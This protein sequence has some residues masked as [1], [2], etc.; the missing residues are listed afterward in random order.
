[1]KRYAAVFS[2][3]FFAVAAQAREI[4]GVTIPETLT[5]D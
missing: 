2:F 1:M 5:I 3:L 4:D